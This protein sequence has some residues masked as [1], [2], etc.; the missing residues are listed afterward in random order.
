MP[1]FHQIFLL[2]SYT[3]AVANAAVLAY[4][5]DGLTGDYVS[6]DIKNATDTEVAAYLSLL[7]P[8]QVTEDSNDLLFDTVMTCGDSISREFAFSCNDVGGSSLCTSAADGSDVTKRNEPALAKRAVK[9]DIYTGRCTDEYQSGTAGCASG[10]FREAFQHS[11]GAIDVWC[12][13]ACSDE[14]TSNCT[15]I[16]CKELKTPCEQTASDK[17][18]VAALIECKGTPVK[19]TET[20]CSL[21]GLPDSTEFA[22]FCRQK[23]LKCVEYKD[24]QCTLLLNDFNDYQRYVALSLF[25]F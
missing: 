24:G 14:E 25:D 6:C 19:T 2:S 23:I 17:D 10:Y 9:C 16:K 8:D 22:A 13:K 11:G 1:S 21:D 5:T 7:Y 4:G 3:A 12:T 18:C 20:F 15:T